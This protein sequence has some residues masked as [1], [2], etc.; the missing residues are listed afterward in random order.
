MNAIKK[1]I[2][3]VQIENRWKKIG[4]NRRKMGAL[5]ENGEPY[6]SPRL[7]G[8]TD[9]DRPARLPGQADGAALP[10]ADGRFAGERL[11]GYIWF[12]EEKTGAA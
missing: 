6:S 4:N 10:G 3:A 7:S 11:N 8:W 1:W 5:L 9:G 12:N 2:L